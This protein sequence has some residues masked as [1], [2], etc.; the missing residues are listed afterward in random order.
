MANLCQHCRDVC[1]TS[2]PFFAFG[3]ADVDL[4]FRRD[5]EKKIKSKKQKG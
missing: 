4:I 5:S 1:F 3:E 2:A